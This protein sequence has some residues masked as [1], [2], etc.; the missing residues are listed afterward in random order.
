MWPKRGEVV[1]SFGAVKIPHVR[2]C[3][4]FGARLVGL[5]GRRQLAPLGGALFI[6]GGSI[7]TFAM[8]FAID[9]L[10]LDKAGVVL[11]VVPALAPWRTSFG[12]R[13]SFAVL[14]LGAGAAAS[15]TKGERMQWSVMA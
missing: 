13:K 7:H 2:V 5:L 14:E 3:A 12:P 11:A 10:Y 1:A 9:V 4:T 15:I 8:K 6:P